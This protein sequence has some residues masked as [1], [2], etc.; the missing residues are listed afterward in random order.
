V[1]KRRA[2]S[3]SSGKWCLSFCISISLSMYAHIISMNRCKYE[4]IYTTAVHTYTRMRDG[5]VFWHTCT[6]MHTCA[7]MHTCVHTRTRNTHTYTHTHYRGID[8]HVNTY[9]HAYIH[10]HTYIHTRT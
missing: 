7:H 4:Y 3:S 9:K 2:G 1:T 8:T 10:V 6:H 5:A